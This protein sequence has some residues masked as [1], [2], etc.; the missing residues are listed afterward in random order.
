[1]EK[2]NTGLIV[3]VIILSLMV[4]GLSSFVIYDKVLSDN[5]QKEENKNNLDSDT[6]KENISTEEIKE[7]FKFVYD[8]IELPEVYCGEDEI[9]SDVNDEMHM[10][11]LSKEYSTY[12]ELINDL[13]KYMSIDVISKGTF[14]STDKSNYVEK[15]GKLYCKE[16]YKGYPYGRGNVDIEL[17]SQSGYKISCIATMELTD[18]SN[19]KTYN[20]VNLTLE[21]DNDNWIITSYEKQ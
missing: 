4:V 18:M 8:Y 12:N 16:Q 2:K 19:N 11:H 3:L 7:I 5:E 14:A 1:M 9:I 13:K 6:T 17:T 10:Y 21:K 20:K 15:N